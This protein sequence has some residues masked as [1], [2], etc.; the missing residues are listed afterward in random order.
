MWL[1]RASPDEPN[2][3]YSAPNAAVSQHQGPVEAGLPGSNPDP[4]VSQPEPAMNGNGTEDD[5]EG[6]VSIDAL[7][8]EPAAAPTT[9]SP[10]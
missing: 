7:L 4:L 9:V 8:A 1:C 3:V 2:P 6:V 5:D 10:A